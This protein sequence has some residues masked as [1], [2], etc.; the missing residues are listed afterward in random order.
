MIP[1]LQGANRKHCSLLLLKTKRVLIESSGL[2]VASL[3]CSK[4]RCTA[5][6]SLA[7]ALT[8]THSQMCSALESTITEPGFNVRWHRCILHRGTCSYTNIHA[9]KRNKWKH[10]L[11]LSLL[12]LHFWTV[13]GILCWEPDCGMRPVYKDIKGWFEGCQ[14]SCPHWSSVGLLGHSEFFLW[15]RIVWL[16]SALLLHICMQ[17]HFLAYSCSYVTRQTTAAKN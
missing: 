17:E 11:S 10:S 12:A 7:P 16:P 15:T 14:T 2:Q 13:Y 6:F 4:S 5:L 1:S 8:S 9:R 3:L